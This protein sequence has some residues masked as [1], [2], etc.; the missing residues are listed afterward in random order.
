MALLTLNIRNGGANAQIAVNSEQIVSVQNLGE[1]CHIV[2][3]GTNSNGSSWQFPVVETFD[4][5]IG[6]FQEGRRQEGRR[7]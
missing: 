4:Y 5:V 7:Q 2:T 1:Y 6:L 3:T